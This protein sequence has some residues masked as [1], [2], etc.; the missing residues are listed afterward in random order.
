MAPA[1]PEFRLVCAACRWPREIRDAAVRDAVVPGLDWELVARIVRRQRVAGLV[2]DALRSAKIEPPEGVAQWLDEQASRIARQNLAAVAETKR[3]GAILDA[4]GIDWITFK[5]LPLAIQAYGTLT[6]K[7][8]NDIDILVAAA[9][10]GRACGLLREAG[11]ARFSPGAEVSDDQVAA[12]MRVSKE[13]GWRHPVTGLIVELHGRLMANPAL[14]PQAVLSA[15]RRRVEIVKGMAVP[16][17]GDALLYPYLFAHGAHHGWFRVKWLAD[18]AALL[19]H[20]G[21]EGAE[22]RYRE[23]RAAGV[24]RCA[25]QA[26]LLAHRLLGLPLAPRF[27]AELE[28]DPVHRR[29][30]TVALGCM[31]G[32]FEAREHESPYARTMLPVLLA[33]LLLRRGIGYKWSE[34]SALA[35]NPVDRANNRLP[36]GLGF[37]Y[38][39]LGGMRWSRRM[40]GLAGRTR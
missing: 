20:E 25:A 21:P 40:L 19:V 5:G 31:G 17:M 6:I 11:Y 7:M 32:D 39:V 3:L 13:S 10:C 37:L 2:A 33:G 9:D 28:R 8:A 29:L 14:L 16:T 27:V 12:W 4:A 36:R 30:L 18:V 23:A 22:A 15:P 1:S 34:L 26:L 38:P 24:G 35:A